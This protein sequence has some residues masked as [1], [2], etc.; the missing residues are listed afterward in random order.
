MEVQLGGP[1]TVQLRATSKD[2]VTTPPATK[3]GL[4]AMGAPAAQETGSTVKLTPAQPL[5]TRYLLIWLTGVPKDGSDGK[6]RGKIA[7]VKVTS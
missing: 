2:T 4:E 1:S 6:Y 5:T 7:E 3:A